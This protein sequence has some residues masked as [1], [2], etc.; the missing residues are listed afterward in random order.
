VFKNFN[1]ISNSNSSC[2]KK[3]QPKY[4]KLEHHNSQN[5]D[6]LRFG[7]ENGILANQLSKIL[8]SP[9]LKTYGHLW[10]RKW[11]FSHPNFYRGLERT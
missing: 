3:F 1:S 9:L 6:Y 4:R 11:D 5:S 8:K 10:C 2:L 7:G